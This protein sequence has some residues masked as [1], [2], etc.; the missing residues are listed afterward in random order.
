M[1]ASKAGRFLIAGSVN[2][3]VF[4]GLYSLL[5]FAGFHYNIALVV[6]YIGGIFGGYLLNRYWTFSASAHDSWKLA[7]Y[8]SVYLVVFLINAGLLGIFVEVWSFNPY[9][10]QILALSVAVFVSF[11]LQNVWVFRK[12]N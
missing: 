4:Y 7:K 2:T 8:V 11:L 12:P 5:V 10:A 9:L 1:I 3:L 6:E